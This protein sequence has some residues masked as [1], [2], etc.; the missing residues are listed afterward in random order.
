[1]EPVTSSL[2][3]EE[4]RIFLMHGMHNRSAKTSASHFDARFFDTYETSRAS[5]PGVGVLPASVNHMWAHDN[6]R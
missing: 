1:M 3:S 6:D 4:V 2:D 5:C